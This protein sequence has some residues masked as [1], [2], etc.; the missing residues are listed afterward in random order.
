[1]TI[2]ADSTDCEINNTSESICTEVSECNTTQQSWS[3]PCGEKNVTLSSCG[4]SS[5]SFSSEPDCLRNYTEIFDLSLNR[6]ENISVAICD[7]LPNIERIDF[8]QNK[9]RFIEPGIFLSCKKTKWLSLR[10]NAIYHVEREVFVG[11]ELLEFLDI[12]INNLSGITAGFVDN[13]VNLKSLDLSRNKI[14]YISDG[15][16]WRTE[17]LEILDLSYN[18]IHSLRASV[19]YGALRLK[20]LNLRANDINTN[21]FDYLENFYD[22][23]SLDISNNSMTSIRSRA[24]ENV[25]VRSISISDM[26][27]LKWISSNAFTNCSHLTDVY[28]QDNKKVVIHEDAFSELDHLKILDISNSNIPVLPRV[29]NLTAVY[30]SNSSVLCQCY[31]DYFNI[32]RNQNISKDMCVIKTR[33][34]ILALQVNTKNNTCGPYIMPEKQ[35]GCHLRISEKCTI[36]C[37]AFGKPWPVVRLEHCP[38]TPNKTGLT[39]YTVEE[40]R[41]VY[42]MR[43][44]ALNQDG[45]YRCS[46]SSNTKTVHRNF[47][48]TIIR[49]NVKLSIL[50]RGENWVIITWGDEKCPRR[51]VIL[52]RPFEVSSQ[53]HVQNIHC[54]WKLYKVNDLRSNTGY[55]I[56]IASGSDIEDKSCVRVWTHQKETNV[57]GVHKDSIVI[58]VLIVSA[59][60]FGVFLIS[61]C[62][63]CASKI[64][65]ISKRYV[66][67]VNSESRDSF[68]SACTNDPQ[69]YTNPCADFVVESSLDS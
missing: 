14:Q 10:D 13:L 36:N 65:N 57:P 64:R 11:L 8:S 9:I 3:L 41:T 50:S 37:R 4:I 63:R 51:P 22:L 29:S 68:R 55:E 16:F 35:D 38:F 28:M 32:S 62:I 26:S 27:R 33:G 23:L 66:Y 7:T 31:K 42:E 25:R 19:F 56:C 54:H 67:I 30:A 59:L 45:A 5:L 58:S 6:L 18:R 20:T 40:N 69:L 17:K 48:V 2:A 24:L 44:N 1:M 61:T 60:V 49:T 52:S 21:D 15:V 53:Y 34:N 46:A 43:I 47:S 12:S 39:C